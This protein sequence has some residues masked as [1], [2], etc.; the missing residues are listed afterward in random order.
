MTEDSRTE[1]RSAEESR[2]VTLRV[3]ESGFDT[4]PPLVVLHGFLGSS[5]NWGSV[6]RRLSDSYHV[7]LADLR[8]HG[9]SP[10]TDSMT[11]ED[12]A[13]DVRRLLD[14]L[15]L[16][17]VR[18]M[19]HSLGGKVAMRFACEHPDRV[20]KLF[21]LDIAPRRYEPE[22]GYIDAMQQIDLSIMD[23]R[24]DAD[25]ALSDFVPDDET[26]AFLL[27]NLQ[28]NDQDEF[29]WLANLDLLKA[30]REDLASPGLDADD[31]YEGPTR[32]IVGG[33]SE[34]IEKGDEKLMRR[35]FPQLEVH[36]LP[37]AGHN[38]H[39][40]GGSDFLNLVD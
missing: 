5:R 33:E 24:R 26:R 2:G 7:F 4:H 38:V 25:E 8:N 23:R 36:V 6:A 12:C 21:V 13:Q 40:E 29:E 17:R 32:W 31:R 11:I 39:V 15:R 19:G 34:Y 37:D 27:T 10:H 20:E 3:R 28:R 1:N 9:R 22:T 14:E 35:H 30:Q 16:E 18:L